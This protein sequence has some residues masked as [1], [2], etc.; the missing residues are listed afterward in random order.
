MGSY[1]TRDS[2]GAATWAMLNLM[3]SCESTIPPPP[4]PLIPLMG[5][6]RPP[7]QHQAVRGGRHGQKLHSGTHPGRWMPAAVRMPA[8]VRMPACHS[9]RF[10]GERPIGAATG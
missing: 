7:P 8:V 3:T 4:I 9:T 1:P 6:T 5:V 10:K 2:L